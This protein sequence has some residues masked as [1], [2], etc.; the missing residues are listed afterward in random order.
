MRIDSGL[1]EH[2]YNGR[3]RIIDGHQEDAASD[4]TVQTRPRTASN[5]AINSTLLSSSL[6]SAL[7]SIEGG[8]RSAATP[9]T[10]EDLRQNSKA[11]LVEAFYLE[12][13]LPVEDELN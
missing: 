13:V 1:S 11:E 12:H 2:F 9:A 5:P 8:R 4:T 10:T 7:W 3:V 6:A